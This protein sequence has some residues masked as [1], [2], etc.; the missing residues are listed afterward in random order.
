[1]FT[2]RRATGP[3]PK[4]CVRVIFNCFTHAPRF[5]FF[6]AYCVF[7]LFFVYGLNECPNP[8]LA[9]QQTAEESALLTRISCLETLLLQSQKVAHALQ[10]AQNQKDWGQLNRSWDRPQR[11]VHSSSV[12]SHFVFITFVFFDFILFFSCFS[13]FLSPPFFFLA[14]LLF[15]VTFF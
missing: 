4:R 15:S 1:M 3:N 10:D 14:H 7:V 8:R 13:Q 6:I 12:S 9:L 11:R 5:V 2:S